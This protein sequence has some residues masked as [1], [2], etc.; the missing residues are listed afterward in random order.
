M[1]PADMTHS[2]FDLNEHI[3]EP[4]KEFIGKV[5]EEKRPIKSV[6]DAIKPY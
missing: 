4:M 6:L 5:C 3:I 1:Y 2:Y